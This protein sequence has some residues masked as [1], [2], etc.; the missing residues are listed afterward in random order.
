[1]ECHWLFPQAYAD[2]AEFYKKIFALHSTN[3]ANIAIDPIVF[4]GSTVT[5]DVD[6]RNYGFSLNM[7]NCQITVYNMLDPTKI[8][9]T[10]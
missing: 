1:M 4:Q 3:N 5:F 10:R 8:S 6:K 7:T 2:E 9:N